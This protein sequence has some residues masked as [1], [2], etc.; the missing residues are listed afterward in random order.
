VP[1]VKGELKGELNLGMRESV[2]SGPFGAI[3]LFFHLIFGWPAYLLTG[4][5]GG[6]SRGRATSFG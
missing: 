4:A 1:Y 6:S 3:Q 5:T 2:G